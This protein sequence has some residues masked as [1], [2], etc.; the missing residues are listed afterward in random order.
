MASTPY[1]FKEIRPPG[2]PTTS[3]R[4]ARP[5][6][7][8]RL[9]GDSGELLDGRQARGHLGQAVVPQGSH[10]FADRCPFDV[11]AAC[12]GDRQ[13]LELLAHRQELVVADPAF[14]AGLVA[15]WAA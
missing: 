7:S 4:A 11:L 9:D 13:G 10:A 2:S 6:S 12:L 1:E 5:E 15:P 3:R 14:V 8:S